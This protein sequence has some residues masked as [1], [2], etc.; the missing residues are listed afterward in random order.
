MLIEFVLNFLFPPICVSCEKDMQNLYSKEEDKWICNLCKKRIIKFKK[1]QILKVRNIYY[2][3]FVY[4]FEYKH[5]IRKLMLNYKFKSRPYIS[6]F[7]VEI[8]LK[9]KNLCR[10]ILNYDIIIPVP[11]SR[12][13]LKKRGYNQT[14]LVAKG[15]SKELKIETENL[16]QKKE[17]IKT[18]SSL[19]KTGR[20]RNI[21][22]AFYIEKEKEEKVKNKRVILLDDIFTTGATAR[23][24]SKKLKEAGA[25]D[26]LVLV[27]AKD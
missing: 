15:I 22:N 26:I 5:I 14:E 11:M 12:Q 19:L 4:I 17:N 27:L 18:Q 21:R 3:K 7:F 1:A 25:K 8:I 6:N 16:L 10:N 23:E 9:D 2:N 24:C 13:K 20:S